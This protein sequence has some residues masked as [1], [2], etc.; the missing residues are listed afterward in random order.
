[1]EPIHRPFIANQSERFNE[2]K[3]L[4]KLEDVLAFAYKRAKKL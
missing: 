2:N 3:E 1:M 4:Y